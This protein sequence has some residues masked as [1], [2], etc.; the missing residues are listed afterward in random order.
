MKKRKRQVEAK[1]APQATVDLP[2]PFKVRVE[3]LVPRYATREEN[4]NKLD[5]ERFEML[6]AAIKEEGFLQPILVT[7]IDE[8]RYQIEDGHHR[9]WGALEHGMPEITAV[10]KQEHPERAKLL[11]IGMNR[12]RGEVDLTA[13]AAVITEA[14]AVLALSDAE[15]SMLT[16]FTASELSALL[17]TTADASDILDDGVGDLEE[18]DDAEVKAEFV[19]EVVF[20]DRDAFKLA[21][22]KLRKMGK[23]D[24]AA[25][26][27]AALGEETASPDAE[28]VEVEA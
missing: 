17:D 22:R 20:T 28:S 25:G 14:Q 4:P 26:L 8:A 7:R 5:D 18:E 23:G 10:F 15:L 1:A 16:G 6:K 13:A 27:L 21:K 12:L 9:Y 19:L 24:L 11:G 3:H 2:I